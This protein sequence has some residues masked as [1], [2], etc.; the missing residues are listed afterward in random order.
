MVEREE[1]RSFVD[2]IIYSASQ[3]VGEEEERHIAVSFVSEVIDSSLKTL[4]EELEERPIAVTKSPPVVTSSAWAVNVT[5][6]FSWAFHPNNDLF[7]ILL[8]C[9]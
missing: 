9:P 1:A 4:Q 7:R 6:L 8:V 5:A 3:K 2:G